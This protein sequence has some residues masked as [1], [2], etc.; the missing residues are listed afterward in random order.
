MKQ[1]IANI[2]ETLTSFKKDRL[3]S[4]GKAKKESSS[5]KWF[6]DQMKTTKLDEKETKTIITEKT[7]R[8]FPYKKPGYVYMFRYVPPDKKDMPF[9]DEYPLILTLGF[10]GNTVFGINLHYVPVRTRLAMVLLILKSLTND[11]DNAKIRME[12]VIRSSIFRKYIDVLGEQFFFMGIK[13]KIRHVTPDEFVIMSFLPTYKFRKK[14]KS[15]ILSTVKSEVK[16][17]K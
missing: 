9:Y 13:S 16:K 12:N 8:Q 1:I 15:Q 10:S 6:S 2:Q 7:T 14:S 11:K 4:K 5:I 3:D 17:R